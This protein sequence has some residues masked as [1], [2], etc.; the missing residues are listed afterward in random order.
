[1]MLFMTIVFLGAVVLGILFLIPGFTFPIKDRQGHNVSR[2]IAS[3][4]KVNLGGQEQWILI[5]SIDITKPVILFLHGGPGTSNMCLLRKYTDELEKHFIV[6]TWDQRGAGKSYQAINPH[7]SMTIDRFV[8]DTGE[9]TQLLCHRFD[10]KKI[11]LVG[12][13][14]G[15]L[16][17]ILSIQK[18]PDSYHAYIGTGQI[19]NMQENEQISYDWTLAQATK[20]K[21]NQAI[22]TLTEIGNP[23]Y[24]GDGQKKMMTQRRLL[25]KYGGELYGSQKGAFPLIFSS[26]I[27]ATEYTL[28]DKV[29]FFK[30]IFASNHLLWQKL[31]TINLK[32]QELSFK[33]PIYF[34]LGK[35]DYEVPS[36]IAEQYFEMIEAPKK[37][38]IWFE[39]SAHLANIEENE[40]FNNLLIDRVLPTISKS[41]DRPI[42]VKGEDGK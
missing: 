36:V 6:V 32:K 40:K 27:S 2:S 5:R 39:N 10:Q 21:D 16:I 4:E 24:A 1:M 12:H 19:V 14:W 28:L 31:L 35:H 38:L 23:P 9:L 41:I 26:L 15:S 42:Y 22:R 7:S 37:E 11:F 20:A 33:V 18:Y 3:L 8:L 29:N 13:S 30:G 17:G 25:G 34:A